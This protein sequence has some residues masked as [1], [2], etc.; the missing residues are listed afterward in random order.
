MRNAWGN[1]ESARSFRKIRRFATVGLHAVGLRTIR[2]AVS[3]LRDSEQYEFLRF[4]LDFKMRVLAY[5]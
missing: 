1:S 2:L 3:S 5:R 4:L